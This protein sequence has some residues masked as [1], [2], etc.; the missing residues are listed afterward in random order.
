MDGFLKIITTLRIPTLALVGIFFYTG[1]SLI[2]DS[3][4]ISASGISG[5]ILLCGGFILSI[6]LFVDYRYKEQNEHIVEQQSKAI[7]NLG[8]ALKNTSDTHSKIE[9]NTQAELSSAGNKIGKDGGKQ[10][11]IEGN[12]ETSTK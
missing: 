6:I 3:V 11:S 4:F 9:K 5:G 1:Y 7:D 2:K 8:R 10:Y 12:S